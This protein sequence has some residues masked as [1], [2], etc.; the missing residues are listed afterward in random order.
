MC[1]IF[2]YIGS[3]TIRGKEK[4]RLCKVSD[5]LRHRGPDQQQVKYYN[6]NVMMAF[7]RL[8]IVDPTP[9]GIQP[10]ESK[11]GRFVCMCNGEIYN[12]REIKSFL[13][14]KQYHVNWKTHSD[15]EVLVHL[16]D[17]LVHSDT[18]TYNITDIMGLMCKNHL[19]G[20]YSMVIYDNQE[21]VAYFSTDELSMRP[22]FIG[23]SRDN[24]LP[25]SFIASEQKALTKYCSDG[26][27]YRISAGEYGI[28]SSEWNISRTYFSMPLVKEIDISFDQAVINF[29]NLLIQN[30]I[31]KLSPDREYAF[32]L[33]GGVDSSLV[34]A[35]AAREIYPT[36][37]KTFTVGFSTDATDILAA[38]KVAKHIDSI[39]T[40][41]IC[42]Y[43]EGIVMIPT[44]IYHNESW[45]QT[46]TRA[47]IPM[48]LCIKKIRE[49][50]PDVAVIFSG[51]V[52]DEMLRGYLYNIKTPSLEVWK[53]DQIMRLQNL[54]TSDGI[55]ADRVCATYSF[56]CRFP[57]FSKELI[58]FALEVP[59]RYLNPPDNQGIEKYLMRKAFD[60]TTG[61]GY[62]YLPQD[63]LWR[64]KNAFSDATSVKSG[65]KDHL[66]TYCEKQVSDSRFAKRQDLYPYCTPQTK[67]DMYYR[68]LF[69]GYGYD[70]TTIPYKWISSWCGNIT[71][72][73]A[74]KLDVFTE[75]KIE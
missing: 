50:H 60:T 42:S 61:D 68:E 25:G 15:C 67:E 7:Y 75:D 39:H 24:K 14:E 12:Y 57:F 31:K 59:P 45:D 20:E 27:I 40:E 4:K 63:I 43:E 32:L 18:E 72:S 3:N 1:G 53:Q 9:E 23:K 10:F 30:V 58:K 62:E 47:S 71:D 74:S 65:W 70:P 16:F 44:A 48:L 69:D 33:S 19:D 28:L 37:I 36:R 38:R 6:D 41:F 66:I 54:H 46:T 51:E 13:K 8:A 64:T 73:S 29:R 21:S 56:E 52:A 55:R 2:L 22:I 34:C 26:E 35:I 11:D 5:K 49:K 17:Y